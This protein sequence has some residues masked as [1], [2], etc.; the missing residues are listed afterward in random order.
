MSLEV[1]WASM[2]LPLKSIDPSVTFFKS[3][4]GTKFFISD[5]PDLFGCVY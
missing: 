1:L 3:V 2:P 4:L 5:F